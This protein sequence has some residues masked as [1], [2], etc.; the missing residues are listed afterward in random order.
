MIYANEGNIAEFA[1]FMKSVD[2]SYQI[3]E[4][5]M[6]RLTFQSAENDYIADGKT[7]KLKAYLK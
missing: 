5:E 7:G 2:S 6:D 4:N 1:K 3:D